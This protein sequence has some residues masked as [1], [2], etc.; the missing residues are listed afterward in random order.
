MKAPYQKGSQL[1]SGLTISC[2][3]FLILAWSDLPA[4]SQEIDPSKPKGS[5]EQSPRF[6]EKVAEYMQARVRVTG[7]SGAVLVARDGRPVFREGYGLANHELDVANTPKM[8][9]RLGSVTKQFTAATILLLE[10]RGKLNVADPLNKYL[11]DWPKAWDQVTLHHLLSHTGG[12]PKLTT[13]VLLDVS[14]LSKAAPSPFG[15]IRDLHKPGEDLQPLDFKPGEK[16]AY[17]N[18]GYIVL[19][20]VIEKVSGK[21]YGEFMREEIFRPLGMTDTD[22][23]EPTMILKSR[24]SGYARSD[25]TIVNA[26]YVDMRFPGAAGAIFSTV[27]DLLLWDRMLAS[28]RL[29]SAGARAKLFTMVKGDYACGWWVQT[30]FKR[31]AHWHRGNVSGFIAMIA[32]Y[33]DEGIF[34][35]VL[36]NVERT[37][38]RAVANELAAIVFGEKYEPPRERKETRIEPA[39]FEDCVGKYSKDGQ[40]DDTFAVAR[41]VNK[42]VMQIPPGHTVF[43]IFPESPVHFFAKWGEYYLTFVKS[44]KGNVTHVLI[45]NEGEES[46]WT[47]LPAE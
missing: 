36:S 14:G 24:A 3:G 12:L 2:C 40:P 38:V 1:I 33:P 43:E 27:D 22:C 37:P 18:N 42:L 21:A 26:G 45:R 39:T 35:A 44:D 47:K 19:G 25:G 16:F 31:K 46:R 13:Q 30:K 7:F 17:N 8:K 34:I 32:R 10:E 4:W 11:S 5:V 20:M 28:D 23:E 29:L 9:F 15:G 6:S 41:D